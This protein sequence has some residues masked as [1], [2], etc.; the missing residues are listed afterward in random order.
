M[1]ARRAA[2]EFN[3]PRS[4]LKDHAKGRSTLGVRA[5][6]KRCIPEPIEN[7]VVDK[8]IAAARLAFH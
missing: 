8:A 5:G 3:V 4:T 1:S 2:K 7:E 6:R